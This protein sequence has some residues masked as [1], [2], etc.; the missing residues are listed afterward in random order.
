[1]RPKVPSAQL[2]GPLEAAQ[3]L[4]ERVSDRIPQNITKIS[5]NRDPFRRAREG[6]RAGESS[7]FI[8][9]EI[10]FQWKRRP[11]FCTR[12]GDQ[13]SQENE[14][15]SPES[16]LG[17]PRQGPRWLPRPLST[18]P[19]RQN[20]VSECMPL[21]LVFQAGPKEVPNGTKAPKII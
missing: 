1:M 14:C 8:I 17:C 11:L 2:L 13:K 21:P 16:F 5:P 19:S 7:I 3:T 20:R 15:E 4:Q 18:A 6:S 9:S 12:F 10:S